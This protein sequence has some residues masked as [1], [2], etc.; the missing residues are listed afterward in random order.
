VAVTISVLRARTNFCPQVFPVSTNWELVYVFPENFGYYLLFDH[1]RSF[2]YV[3]A[4]HSS[5]LRIDEVLNGRVLVHRNGL[6]KTDWSW[7]VGFGLLL[8]LIMPVKHANW[9]NDYVVV[10]QRYASSASERGFCS[11]VYEA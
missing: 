5:P 11:H 10:G 7:L 4:C 2:N 1:L 6:C 3:Q 9:P 8:R